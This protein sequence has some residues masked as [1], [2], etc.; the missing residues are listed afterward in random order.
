MASNRGPNAVAPPRSYHGDRDAYF[1]THNPAST[2]YDWAKDPTQQAAGGGAAK[3]YGVGGSWGAPPSA[4]PSG[5]TD[6]PAMHAPSNAPTHQ[7]NGASYGGSGGTAVSDGSYER[8]LIQELCPPGGMRAE[9][10]LDRL[11][12]YKR[13]VPSLNPDLVCPALLDQL[14]EGHPWLVRAKALCVIETTIQV[15]S[16]T[17]GDG[18][19]NAYS[20]FFHACLSE[21]EPLASHSRAALREPAKRVLQLLG[22][23]IPAKSTPP[24]G[25]AQTVLPESAPTSTTNATADL[26]DFGNAGSSLVAPPPAA[27]PPVAPPTPSCDESSN[28]NIAAGGAPS[29]LFG[30]LNIN[31]RIVDEQHY[32]AAAPEPGVEVNDYDQAATQNLASVNL[33]DNS[34]PSDVTKA[35]GLFSDM[36]IKSN[37]PTSKMVASEPLI[38]TGEA[39]A[40]SFINQSD[41]GISANGSVK[42]EPLP[43]SDTK[44]DAIPA[45][46]SANST[47]DPLLS[48]DWS[49]S[50]APSP[51]QTHQEKVARMQAMAAAQY[52]QNNMMMQQMQMRNLMMQQHPQRSASVHVMPIGLQNQ[53]Q[54]QQPLT[55]R[56]V[57]R[58]NSMKQIPLFQQPGG[59]ATN[60]GSFSFL[61]DDSMSKKKELQQKSFDFVK[62]AMK[63]AK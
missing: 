61:A 11:E 36:S 53:N 57:M 58:A 51:A 6:H 40:F 59:G 22:V 24:R 44:L 9:P 49:A 23:D 25:S 27:S 7:Q 47:F 38:N 10:P 32:T 8:N 20:D 17:L 63:S 2:A 15:A 26:L 45:P 48:L 1:K 37:A 54:Q 31:N 21:I 52:Q 43:E 13:S 55:P 19:G 30:G 14:E 29:S 50:A 56:S 35:N 34:S 39:S 16:T 5:Q 33:L 41:S 46:S 3:P 60:V 18:N 62:D 4:P 28:E 12:A 42:S